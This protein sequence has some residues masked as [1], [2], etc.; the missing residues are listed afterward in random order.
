MYPRRYD[1]KEKILMLTFAH[2][3][4]EGYSHHGCCYSDIKNTLPAIPALSSI[5]IPAKLESDK[6]PNRW[7]QASAQDGIG[8]SEAG[9]ASRYACFISLLNRSEGALACHVKTQL[10]IVHAQRRKVANDV[11][12]CQTEDF[13]SL[14]MGSFDEI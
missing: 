3:R 5:R 14:Q 7:Q 6:D 2:K 10:C 1:T 4:E 11:L 13:D 8:G 9:Q 12:F